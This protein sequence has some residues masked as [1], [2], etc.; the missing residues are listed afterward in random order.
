MP[1]GIVELEPSFKT[2]LGV[3]ICVI[4]H[5]KNRLSDAFATAHKINENMKRAQFM[6]HTHYMHKYTQYY[7]TQTH[8][9][10]L[11]I[12]CIYIYLH[13]LNGGNFMTTMIR[14]SQ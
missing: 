4:T 6:T 8:A 7:Y 11:H 14:L 1:F 9:C 12:M 10:R 2:A 5:F 3:C 13:V